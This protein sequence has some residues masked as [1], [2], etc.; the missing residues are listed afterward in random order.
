MKKG[1]KILG[2]AILLFLLVLLLIPVFFK[3]QIKAKVDAE[4]AKT[5]NAEV[6]FETKNFH[7]SL[8][9]NFPNL[10]IGINDFS[11][12]GKAEAFNG[13]TLFSVG[14]MRFTADVLSFFRGNQIRIVKVSLDNPYI[15]TKFTEDG[16]SSW[17]IMIRDE[18]QVEE[19]GE[20][21]GEAS[22]FS[23]GIDK[24]E[25][26]NAHI[27]YEDA[28]MPVFAELR[29]MNH[30]GSGDFTQ[31]IFDLTTSTF[32]PR[33]KVEYDGTTVMDEYAV[34]ADVALHMNML[35]SEY[36]FLDNQFAINNF[37]FGFDGMIS[38][39]GDDVQMDIVFNAAET[40]FK[41]LIS[42]IPAAY[43]KDY[44][45]L[46]AQGTFAFDGYAK[47]VYNDSIMPAFGLLLKVDEAMVKY[48]DLPTAVSNINLDMHVENKDGIINHTV[49]DIRK[50][51]MN[52]G[53]NPVE[54]RLLVDGFGPYNIDAD[55]SANVDL[56][57]ITQLYPLDGTDLKGLFEMNVKAKGTYSETQWP[58][59][60]AYMELK[61]GYVKNA[62]VPAPLE[63]L[64]MSASLS[65]KD[66]SL[67]STVFNLERFNM[68]FQNEPFEAKALVRNLEN[69]DYDV[70]F[71]G[72][73]DLK[74]LTDLYPLKDMSLAGRVKANIHTKGN[75]ASIEAGKYEQTS[76]RGEMQVENLVYS[77]VALPQGVK[78]SNAVFKLTPE[79]MEI[80][81]MQGYVGESDIDVSGFFA[82]YMGYMFS[83]QVLK[84]NMVFK[85]NKFDT[86]E[87]LSEEGEGGSEE[88]A[89]TKAGDE[90]PFEVPKNIDFVL[91]TSIH[92][93]LYDNMV[94]AD[95]GGNI[96]VRDGIMKMDKLRFNSLG[97][98][99]L[100]NGVYNTQDLQA[101]KFDMD[102]E[103]KGV[104][105]KEAYQT[106]NTM[107]ALAPVAE[108]MDGAFSTNLK[109][110]GVLGN[111][112]SPVMETVN[113][114][115]SMKIVDA[116]L[117]G[118]KV[119]G[120]IAKLTKVE[121]LDPLVLKDVSLSFKIVDGNLEVNPFDL[122]AGK[123][124]MNIGGKQSLDGALDYMVKMDIPAGNVGAA[125]NNAMSKITGKA[126]DGSQ[127]IKLD[128]GISGDF[129]DP[130]VNLLSSS[131]KEQVKDN[132]KKEAE[133]RVRE[134]IDNSREAQRLKEEKERLDAE[135]ERLRQEAADRKKAEEERLRKEAEER[136]KAEEER[137]RDKVKDRI[138]DGLKKPRF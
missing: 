18:T 75:M 8:I 9:R 37:K 17:D 4:L 7:L 38:M 35:T 87:W 5:I 47:G 42:M 101:P 79:K 61:D 104:H 95:L 46:E 55:I 25:I 96:V 135:R 85:S 52:L 83:D 16:K 34:S 36:R 128:L 19:E 21:E 26:K 60:D 110:A 43:L 57:E 112:M 78:L 109:M 120:G 40:D 100:A 125:V 64:N 51:Q 10:S 107:Q 114:S 116:S 137:L 98:S 91:N 48:P 89:D 27:V 131:V 129:S 32:I 74:K 84:G 113:G 41:D 102:M 29:G 72:I 97:G 90:A 124:K 71:K 54:G 103:L 49:L 105:I 23:F 70:A 81:E 22:E 20:S 80:A 45:G 50:L 1:L 86:N 76:T 11:L 33:V 59:V 2:G 94:L 69:P 13:D 132:V 30:T 119:M 31:D 126:T 53:G 68:L 44:E 28:A 93:V 39:L 123:I 92:E 58:V 117:K 118:N 136:R 12:V 3:D 62:D 63:A 138:P 65:N 88:G 130:K 67:A 122:N 66:G 82:N 14:S 24:W 133:R 127:D 6:N 115:G 15:L 108:N 99:F 56:S 134:Q 73:L 106:F 121:G 111:D 77:S